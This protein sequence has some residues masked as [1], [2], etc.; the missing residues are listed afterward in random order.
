MEN[1]RHPA[2][3]A[4]PS[5]ILDWCARRLPD[6]GGVCGSFL[7]D[8]RV[9]KTDYTAGDEWADA[10]GETLRHLWYSMDTAYCAAKAAIPIM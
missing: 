1:I 10:I 3:D 6:S 7:L 2:P 5:C 4:A 8:S 9:Y